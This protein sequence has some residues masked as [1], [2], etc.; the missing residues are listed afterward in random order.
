MLV[1]TCLNCGQT[2]SNGKFC[3]HC[4][5]DADLYAGAIRIS[6]SLYN[7]GLAKAKV[8]DLSGAI[9]C[10]N[11]SISVNKNNIPARNLLGLVQYEMGLVGDA[12]KNWVISCGLLKENNPAMGYIELI[13]RNGRALERLNDAIYCY[14]QALRD[15]RQKS[16]D[17]AI[18]K[19]KQA[20][21][22][23]SKFVPALNLLALCYMMQ[24]DRDRAIATVERVLSIDINNATALEYYA[25]L[26]P[27]TSRSIVPRTTFVR[28]RSTPEPASGEISAPYKK[29]TIKDSKGV[30]FH[31][32]GVISLVVGVL[33]TLGVVFVMV[34]PAI[35][36]T[37]E[38]QMDNLVAQL[39]QAEQAYEYL[40]EEKDEALDDMQSQINQYRTREQSLET[41]L[42][43]L[44]RSV[45]ILA[46]YELMREGRMR[47]AVDGLGTF[48]TS[49]LRQDIVE[50]EQIVRATAYPV[51]ADQY[52][53]EGLLA[54]NA[55]DF[56]KA[57]I[58]FER[59]YRY[60]QHIDDDNLY[61]EVL[62]Y[63]GWTYSMIEEY[64]LAE[65]YFLRLIEEFP[66][67]RR[68]TPSR[69]RLNVIRPQG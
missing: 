59:A 41:Q 5:V 57:R 55:W 34:I 45:Q 9:E 15:M 36:R 43:I 3:P 60:V 16:D 42:D 56:D 27:S 25:E 47:E 10:L 61:I 33:C 29:V 13:Q 7:K 53:R 52:F 40:L 64:D 32:A 24:K 17:M 49:G 31:L 28:R 19:L 23:N 8:S 35:N 69:N 44:N 54:Y 48:D 37:H 22:L 58:D 2:H 67:S 21:D 26:G 20:V 6:D 65:H 39:A 1:T 30:S 46:S 38:N 62:Y 51:L 63:L 18:I 68:V 12:I 14:N 11:K 50:R 4:K 66:N